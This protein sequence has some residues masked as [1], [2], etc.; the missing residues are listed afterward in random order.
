MIIR[1]TLKN[2][3]VAIS[4][5]HLEDIR[6]YRMSLNESKKDDYV[7]AKWRREKGRDFS[8]LELATTVQCLIQA[9]LAAAEIRDYLNNLKPAQLEN[10]KVNWG[11]LRTYESYET[12]CEIRDNISAK[13]NYAELESEDQKELDRVTKEIADIDR[14]VETQMEAVADYNEKHSN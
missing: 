3:K 12:L 2:G 13:G 9:K 11:P 1:K 5:S 7:S 8:D 4:S 14:F 6:T 10:I